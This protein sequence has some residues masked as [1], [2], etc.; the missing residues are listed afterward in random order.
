MELIFLHGT[1][2]SGKLTT[3]RAL[4]VLLGFP[5]FHNHLVVDALTTVF[6][7]GSEP[8]V[9]LREEFWLQVFTDAARTARSL[10][11]TFAPEATV[12]LGFPARVRDRVEAFGGQV[13][14][15]R[16]MVS[17]SEQERRIDN[18]D[19]KQ[20]HKLTDIDTLRRLRNYRT[21]IELPPV[22]LEICTDTTTAHESAA[23]IVSR[24]Q[25][26][27]QQTMQRYPQPG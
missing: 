12:Q 2:A 15:V 1:A 10:T 21:G 11:F 22:D 26:T 9:R 16:L 23:L 25:L 3:A 6:P 24:F 4:E 18:E 17:E 13:C 20:F 19:R 7:F 14:F 5:V 27:P 8:F